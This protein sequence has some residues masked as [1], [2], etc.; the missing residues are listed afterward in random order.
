MK[1]TILCS[2]DEPKNNFEKKIKKVG[3][4]LEKFNTFDTSNVRWKGCLKDERIRHLFRIFLLWF[5]LRID[6]KKTFDILNGK[7]GVRINTFERF[8]K[9][10]LNNIEVEEVKTY[11]NVFFGQGNNSENKIVFDPEASLNWLLS[12]FEE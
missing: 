2:N 8:F 11:F 4:E 9:K 7:I 3:I 6:K 5:F 12:Y 10:F 1:I